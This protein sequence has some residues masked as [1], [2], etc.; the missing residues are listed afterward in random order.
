MTPEREVLAFLRDSLRLAV[1]TWPDPERISTGPRDLL[2]LLSGL[3]D[4]AEEVAEGRAPDPTDERLEEAAA[5]PL[6]RL[7]RA[8]REVVE[9]PTPRRLRALRDALL[10]AEDLARIRNAT[11]SIGLLPAAALPGRAVHR[12]TKPANPSRRP[13][14]DEIDP[15]Q[16]A[17]AHETIPSRRSA[18]SARRDGAGEPR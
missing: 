10:G 5:A 8:V 6:D 4:L 1:R 13:A 16:P 2:S 17:S 18:R 12:D 11:L 9:R 15:G 7:L 3:V 14:S